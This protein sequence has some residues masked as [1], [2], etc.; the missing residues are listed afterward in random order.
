MK[1]VFLH[2]GDRFYSCE[3]K[4][5]ESAL[6][7]VIG[8]GGSRVSKLKKDFSGVSSDLLRG[9]YYLSVREPGESCKK[10]CSQFFSVVATATVFRITPI[11]DA[12]CGILENTE[13]MKNIND[14]LSVQITLNN[15]KL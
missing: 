15:T 2:G 7:V 14:G 13:T 6:G 3:F 10:G 5:Q 11:D 8:K 12:Q 4:V 9:N 1:A